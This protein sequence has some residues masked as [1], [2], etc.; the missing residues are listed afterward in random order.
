[1]AGNLNVLLRNNFILFIYLFISYVLFLFLGINKNWVLQ[2]PFP[3]LVIKL[4]LFGPTG[5]ILV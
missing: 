5:F 1:M 4:V 2:I 3:G